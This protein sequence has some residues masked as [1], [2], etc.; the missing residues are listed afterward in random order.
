MIFLFL[1]LWWQ[2][3]ESEKEVSCIL[4]NGGDLSNATKVETNTT[5]SSSQSGGG[6][7]PT[8][9]KK[10]NDQGVTE[11]GSQT[12]T[13]TSKKNEDSKNGCP[14]DF[15]RLDDYLCLHLHKDA[16]ENGI[17]SSFEKSKKYCREKDISSGLLQFVNAK[18][19]SK[20]WKWLG[21]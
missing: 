13:D 18:E 6:N 19:A 16:D 5:K 21:N 9:R 7:S 1:N 20:I 15:D 8:R 17:Q 2:V 11:A 12:E 3:D 10:R 14:K 4:E